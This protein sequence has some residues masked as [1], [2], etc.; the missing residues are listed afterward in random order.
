[1]FAAALLTLVWTLACAAQDAERDAWQRIGPGQINAPR[2]SLAGM[3]PADCGSAARACALATGSGG[4]IETFAG[5][6]L[7][8]AELRFASG[9]L[10]AVSL[11]F[12]EEHYPALLRV[13]HERYGAGE[14]RNYQAR[15]GMA[16]EFTAHI[17]I[18]TVG[19]LAVVLEQYA[20]K[21]DRSG[22]VYGTSEA[23]AELLRVKREVSPGARRDL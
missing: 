19:D 23:M 16:G 3:L 15:A 4:A 21:I 1:M 8:R 22:V 5:I 20:G 13:L 2:E 11:H 9:R 18:W 17:W 6:P 14:D 10:S 12:S 7:R